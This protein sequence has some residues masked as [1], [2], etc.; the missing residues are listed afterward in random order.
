MERGRPFVAFEGTISMNS[1]TAAFLW[2]IWRRQRGR[3]IAVIVTLACFALFYPALCRYIGLDLNAPNALDNLVPVLARTLPNISP[4]P[5]VFRIFLV[6]FLL[7]GPLG[8]MV[9][10]QLYATWIFTFGEMDEVKGFAMPTRFFRLPVSPNFL[11]AWLMGFGAAA[12]T[13]LY[14]GWTHLVHLPRIDVF[15]GFP[16]LL[17]WLTVLWVS[18]AIVWS[19]DGFPTIRIVALFG[20]LYCLGYLAGPSVEE[21]PIIAKNKTLLFMAISGF[22]WVFGFIGLNKLRQGEWQTIPWRSWY[23]LSY[24]LLARRHKPTMSVGFQSVSAAQLWFEW[25]KTGR[26]LLFST[27]GLVAVG[28]LVMTVVAIGVGRLSDGDLCGLF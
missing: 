11:A 21:F 3:L 5:R 17:V 20:A 12:I 15:S 16:N 27:C 22:G 1:P 14:V 24:G 6:L 9:V 26:K 10:S 23:H 13:L 8:C 19:L 4:L 28:L 7:L 25:R 18:Q 2:Q